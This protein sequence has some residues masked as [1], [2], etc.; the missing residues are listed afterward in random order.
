[1]ISVL[2]SI[3]S[4][5]IPLYFFKNTSELFEFNKVIALY[6]FTTL[7]ISAWAVESI[8]KRKV[9]FNHSILDWPLIIYLIIYLFSTILSIDP[10]SSVLGYYSRFN[11]GLIT[12]ICYAL[13][14]WA[15][16][17]NIKNKEAIKI[18]IYG[19]VG[20]AVASLL[21]IG[22]HFGLFATCGMM[23]LGWN[24]SCWVQDVQN[25]VFSTLGQPN[26]LAAL[27][28]AVLPLSWYQFMTSASKANDIPGFNSLNSAINSL[29]YLLLSVLLFLTLVFTKSRSGL[30]AFG[31]EAIIFWGFVFFKDKAKYVKEF[32]LLNFIFVLFYFIF[33]SPFKTPNLQPEVVTGPV[34]E[35][36]GT[37]SGTI[38]KY[39]WIGAINVFKHFPIL[40][41]G[42]ETFAFSYPMFKPVGH[43][44]TSEWDFVYNKAH[45]EFL[46]Y[47]ATTGVIGFI[48]YLSLISFS[49][50]IIFKSKRFDYL[51][52][53]VSILVTNFFGFSVV[54]VSLLFFLLP[55]LA[56]INKEET[57][58][59]NQT[60]KLGNKEWLSI[61]VVV[62][63]AGYVL[64][65]IYKYWQADIS[66][67]SAKNLNRSNKPDA[68]IVEINKALAFE[69]NEPIFIYEL[70]LA[71]G[72]VETANNALSLSPFNQNL[73]KILIS[74]LVKN[75]DT[76]PENM[77]LAEDVVKDGI[78]IS[79]RDP[80]LYY[81][82]GILNLKNNKIE[83]GIKNFEKSVELKANYK[84]A[85][86]A[87]GLTY[88][89]V[90]NFEKAKENLDYILKYI[91]PNDELTKKYLNKLNEPQ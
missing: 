10:R 3:L 22:E 76:N 57:T 73:R 23:K 78:D 60:K 33:A 84:E 91:D 63:I 87:L 90:K 81:Q 41:S 5:T 64:N 70:A 48:S 47:L 42:P 50:F 11:G 66:F 88:I 16:V 15:F 71:D 35:S 28:V 20:T 52:A 58:K 19:L 37:E 85:R 1:M 82:L 49:I 46:N 53:Y 21:A 56:V 14:Y 31:V 54:P 12:Q 17:S 68:A 75:V 43:N 40:G 27:V 86:F 4:L 77:L 8:K 72:T 7:I 80:R 55:A 34:L 36:G 29:P 59:E 25:R 62:L 9:I 69:P 65:L 79:P 44:L 67:N 89:D 18:T 30:L 24:Q 51:A 38:R 83:E 32:L 39:V 74:N 13:L 26:W 45:N 6:G 2:F 61:L